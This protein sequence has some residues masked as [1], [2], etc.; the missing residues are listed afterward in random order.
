MESTQEALVRKLYDRFN[1][2]DIAGVVDLLD[3]EVTMPDVLQGTTLQGA[4]ALQRYWERHFALVD[5]SIKV[6]EIVEVGDA[7]LV[8]VYQ[9]TYN[10]ENGEL[11]GPGVVAV[12][13]LAF[14]GE[15]IRSIE[16][17]GVDEVPQA[18]RQRLG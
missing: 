10:R 7:V 15:R 4:E 16:Y 8:V 14:R 11:L 2:A 9:E 5:S 17:T 18:V 12:H 3:P 13:R 1:N 6:R